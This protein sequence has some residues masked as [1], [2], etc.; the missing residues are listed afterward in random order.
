MPGVNGVLNVRRC[1]SSAYPARCLPRRCSCYYFRL[2]LRDT[3]PYIRASAVLLRL[4]YVATPTRFDDG[5]MPPVG[6]PRP[7]VCTYSRLH[8]HP[9][10]FSH[11]HLSS[12]LFLRP[13]RPPPPPSLPRDLLPVAAETYGGRGNILFASK[14][15]ERIYVCW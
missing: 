1:T 15:G 12:S 2:L 11:S 13:S 14:Q 8:P 7:R 10:P 5:S 6:F 4:V 3:R 9:F